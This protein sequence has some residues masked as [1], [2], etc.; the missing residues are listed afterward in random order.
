MQERLFSQTVQVTARTG[1]SSIHS[2]HSPC[3]YC[4]LLQLRSSVGHMDTMD[5]IHLYISTGSRLG[6]ALAYTMQFVIILIQELSGVR[7]K[8]CFRIITENGF[9]DCTGTGHQ[10]S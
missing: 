1:Q 9:V 10:M 7:I 4:S 5:T 6:L 3:C 8:R 2:S